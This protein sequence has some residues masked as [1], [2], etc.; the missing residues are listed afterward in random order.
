V[1]SSGRCGG[2]PALPVR[3]VGSHRAGSLLPRILVTRTRIRGLSYQDPD[4]YPQQTGPG[5]RATL[6]ITT[7]NRV[8]GLDEWRSLPPDDASELDWLLFR[9]NQVLGLD[10]ALV[11]LGRATLRNRLARGQ[12]QRAGRRVVVAH[13]G[14]LTRRQQVWVSVLSAGAG[15]VCGGIT[16]AALAGLRGYDR[17]PV[18]VLVSDG[19]QVRAVPGT[20]IHRT[21]VLPSE[22]VLSLVPPHTTMA[23]AV[24][25]AAAWAARDDDARAVVA[26]AFQQRRVTAEE[27]EAVARMLT[28]SR[29]RSLVLETARYAAGGA[30]S[31]SEV[32]LVRLCRR[33]HL[34]VPDQQVERTDTSGRR[35]YLDAYWAEWRVHVEIDGAFHLEVRTWWADM[36]RQN[37]LWV[38][39]DRVLRYPAW[40]VAHQPEEV[41][42]QI[43][44]ALRAAGWVG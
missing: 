8:L 33:F 42:T 30:H 23:R 37:E 1:N 28:R 12:W 16:A 13:N 32:D 11:N 7:L 25:D 3:Y 4:G 2:E 22:H 21:S 10:Q 40:A 19:R 17:G 31:L 29:R 5:L 24:V 14:P 38:Q 35:R 41:A 27:I 36:R 39:G 44:A 43:R 26:A 34:P 20:R 15:A 6:P 9:Q 18:H